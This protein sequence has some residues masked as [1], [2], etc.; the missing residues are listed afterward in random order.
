[1]AT[2]PGRGAIGVVR[3][4]GAGIV[5][6][7]D[8]LLGQTPPARRAALRDFCDAHG[9][10]I[11]RGIALYFPAPSSYTGEHCLELH[12]HGG[13]VVLKMLMRRCIELGARAARPGEFSERAFLNGRLDLAQAEAVADLIASATEAAARSAMRSLQGEFSA[14]IERLTAQLTEL[15]VLIEAAIDFPDEDIDAA[16]ENDARVTRALTELQQQFAALRAEAARGQRLR[17]GLK[18]VL[19]GP[20]NAGKSS[21][22]NALVRGPRAIVS[23]IAGTTRDVL[24]QSIEVGGMPVEMVD[25]AG[26]REPGDAIEREGVRRARAAQR[27]ADLILLVV[28]DAS[29]T[30]AEIE[31]WRRAI[32]APLCLVRNKIDVSG[33]APGD[34]APDDCARGVAVSALSAQG[35][36]ALLA[37]IQQHAGL[38]DA[39]ATFIARQ[40]HLDALARAEQHLHAGAEQWR[41]LG[42]ELL[43]EELRACQNALGEITGAV[44]ADDLL[45]RIFASF[46]IGK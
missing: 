18:V 37:R 17:D 4:S 1:M 31:N 32:D 26:L 9:A 8:A 10:V 34:C 14:R 24:E 45:G 12:A 36:D 5:A 30:P 27:S 41:A 39:D 15:R 44:G 46:C 20:P 13:A 22:F 3:L 43:A 21:L 6:I 42:G 35:L 40:R 11:D 28:D 29:A 19:S 23:D 25:T 38:G 2:P 33:R 16:R 7:G